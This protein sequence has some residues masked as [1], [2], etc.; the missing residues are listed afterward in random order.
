AGATTLTVATLRS[1]LLPVST[2]LIRVISLLQ[3]SAKAAMIRY[4][5]ASLREWPLSGA[6]T[7]TPY[8]SSQPARNYPTFELSGA[9][10]SRRRVTKRSIGWR[11]PDIRFQLYPV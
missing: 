4:N 6:R 2:R 5:A 8:C 9:V 11:F 1:S 10:D 7:L 3:L